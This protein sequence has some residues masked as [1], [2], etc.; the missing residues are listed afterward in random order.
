MTRRRGFLTIDAVA[1][2]ILLTTLA[3]VLATAI[4]Q[5]VR[6]AN[7]LADSRTASRL[8]EA[9]LFD[10]QQNRP[11]PAGVGVRHLLPGREDDVLQWVQVTATVNG[12]TVALTGAVRRQP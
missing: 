1:G 4:G 11:P 6:A 7:R 12:R 10:L 9:A 5:R 8:A 3:V 2:L